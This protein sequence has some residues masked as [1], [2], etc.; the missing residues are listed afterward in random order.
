MN[1]SP[2]FTLEEMTAS[3]TAARLG[4]DNTPAP[5]ELGELQKTAELLERVRAVT[6][7]PVF[8]TSGYRAPAVNQAVGGAASSAHMW[9]GAADF[10]VP[11]YGSPLE[12][13]RFLATFAESLDFDQLIHEYGGWVHIG[14]AREGKARR[15]LLTIDTSGTR[16]GLPS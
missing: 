12:V 9:G 2:H 11:G 5:A 14:R 10:I 6:E 4:I 3:Q 13:A 8:I 7:R 16:Y 15:Q 1:L